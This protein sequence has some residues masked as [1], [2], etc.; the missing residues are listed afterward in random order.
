MNS[1]KQRTL[2][3]DVYASEERDVHS[4]LRSSCLYVHTKIAVDGAR[5]E[6]IEIP[7]T[8]NRKGKK[9]REKREKEREREREKEK[10]K[11]RERDTAK[12]EEGTEVGRFLVSSRATYR[13]SVCSSTASLFFI[14]LFF[15]PWAR[16]V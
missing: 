16:S 10:G 15:V 11:N 8:R 6:R 14:F 1:K 4:T 3:M 9:V 5:L 13:L 12:N 2:K 7:V